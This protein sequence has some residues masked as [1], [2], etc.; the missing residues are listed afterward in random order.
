[1]RALFVA[2][3]LLAGQARAWVQGGYSPPA[4]QQITVSGGT[5]LKDGVAWVPKGVTMVG[6]LCPGNCGSTYSTIAP[7]FALTNWQTL[8]AAGAD[9]VRLQISQTALDPMSSCYSAAYAASVVAAVRQVRSLGFVVILSMQWQ[10]GGVPSGCVYPLNL[11][12]GDMYFSGSPNPSYQY[13]ATTRA[14]M[15]IAQAEGRDLGVMLELFNEPN[16]QPD[17]SHT[18]AQAWGSWGGYFETLIQTVRAR[19]AQNVLI[20]DCLNQGR[21]CQCPAASCVAGTDG[22]PVDGNGNIAPGR[23]GFS[24]VD[25]L[26]RLAY[27]VHPYPAHAGTYTPA[28]LTPADFAANWGFLGADAAVP[29]IITEIDSASGNACMPIQAGDVTSQQYMNELMTYAASVGIGI[30]GAWAYDWPSLPLVSGS[31]A[32]IVSDF[33]GTLSDFSQWNGC[34]GN[35][36]GPGYDL[37]QWW[38]TGVVPTSK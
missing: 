1:M 8:K 15:Y 35:A 34:G 25:P 22:G 4:A 38:L 30:G 20:V 10:G 37:S 33:A 29:V 19:G 2:L 13:S 24:L 6:M 17:A 16:I 31:F 7:Q 18:W 32:T 5:L 23:Y 28:T 27:G 26:K 14:W 21:E 11:P 12:T 36:A 3:L 9:T